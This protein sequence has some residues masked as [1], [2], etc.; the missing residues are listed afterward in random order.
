MAL[1]SKTLMVVLMMMSAPSQAAQGLPPLPE[2][3]VAEKVA[4]DTKLAMAEAQAQQER[5]LINL[6]DRENRRLAANSPEAQAK[7]QEAISKIRSLAMVRKI[8]AENAEQC[9]KTLRQFQSSSFQMFA[10]GAGQS[11]QLVPMQYDYMGT[12]VMI[13]EERSEKLCQTIIPGQ[14]YIYTLPEQ[15]LRADQDL[16]DDYVLVLKMA[17]WAQNKL[18]GSLEKKRDLESV[19]DQVSYDV[20]N[21]IPKNI[22]PED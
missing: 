21:V 9:L 15:K 14:I 19:P 20:L 8:P 2:K 11:A 3:Y 6:Q 5:E 16:K 12:R 17:E 18:E 10:N 1:A 7:R 22:K 4:T 13:D